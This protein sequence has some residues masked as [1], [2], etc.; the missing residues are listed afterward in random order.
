[1]GQTLRELCLG[2]QDRSIGL[3]ACH[4]GPWYAV[5][6]KG[7]QER[8]IHEAFQQKAIESFLPLYWAARRWSDRVKRVQLPLFPGYLFCRFQPFQRLPLLRTPGVKTIVSSG[9]EMLPVANEDILRIRRLI[10]S[11]CSLEPWPFLQA[12]R[13]VR[14]HSGPLDGLEGIF[15]E[16]RGACG[17]VVSLELLQRS[18]MVSLAREQVTPI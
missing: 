18:V 6:V 9:S 14:V 8:F 16:F 11:N 1:M 12:G 4:T 7:Q 5:M 17:V 3:L 2:A 13:R 10:A 15:A